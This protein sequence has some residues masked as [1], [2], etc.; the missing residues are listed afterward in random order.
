MYIRAGMMDIAVTGGTE[1]AITPLA[2]AGFCNMKALSTRN[3]D[4]PKSS[5]PFDIKRDGFVMG[6][7]AGIV[8][9]ETL[10]HALNRGASIY[11]E[12]AGYGA[13]ADAYHL[14]QPVPEGEG[15]QRSMKA[16]L[17]DA[18][19]SPSDIDYINAHGTSTHFNDKIETYAIKK[20]FGDAVESMAISSTKS[21]TG[22]LLGASGGI[23][24]IACGLVCQ[25]GIIPPTINYE[26]PDPECNL[27]YTPNTAI[28]MPVRY[29][30]SNSFGF[31]GHNATIIVKKYESD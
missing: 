26:D 22:H 2:V 31:G 19:V 10:E 23:E 6:E 4:P 8:V 1:A 5:S 15:A 20:V 11:A 21:M 3:D 13:S 18:G 27:D 17:N 12:I 25:N 30:M 29:A 7:G 28:K 16:A 9:I 14:S 24:C